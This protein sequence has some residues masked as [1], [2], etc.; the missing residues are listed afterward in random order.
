M[1]CAF[2]R[3]KPTVVLQTETNEKIDLPVGHVNDLPNSASGFIV[4][5][6]KRQFAGK[7][8]VDGLIDE[9]KERPCLHFDLS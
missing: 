2:S 7:L 3:R 1:A 8:R 6:K 5:G 4:A 9:A